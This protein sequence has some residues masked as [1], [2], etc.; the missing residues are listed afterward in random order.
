PQAYGGTELFV[1]HLARG[2]HSRGH[3]VTVYANGESKVCGE[4]KWRYRR[5]EWPITDLSAAQLKNMDHTAWA[6]RDAARSVDLIHLNDLVGLPFTTFVDAPVALTLHHPH[7][8]AL[9]Q[10]YLRYPQTQY[11]AISRYQARQEPMPNTT[12]IYHGLR[13]SDY[14]FRA[15]KQDYLVFLGRMAPC[16]GAHVAIEVARHAGLRLKLA[17]EIQPIFAEYWEREVAPHVDGDQVQ[18]VGEADAARKNELL[19][20]ARALLFPIQ[21]DEPFGLVMVE[22]M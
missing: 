6:I 12:V 7:D 10:Q 1:A 15:K 21:W 20:N 8:P 16:K 9:S 11:I 19:S 4:L 17:G 5:S 18:Y 2:L 22:A 14:T 13:L 3:R